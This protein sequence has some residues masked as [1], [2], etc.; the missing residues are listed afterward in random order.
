MY[1]I[2]NIFK[3]VSI[4]EY[5]NYVCERNNIWNLKNEL[6]NYNML[7]CISLYEILIKFNSLIFEKFNLNIT[8][9]PT[10]PSLAFGIYRA[11]F[12]NDYKIP[13][14]GGKLYEDIRKSYTGGAT[15]MYIPYGTNLYHYD[16]NSL[17]PTSMFKFDMP[18]GNI[19]YFTGNIL[20]FMTNPFGFFKVKIITPKYLDNPILQIRY[21]DRTVSPLG[22]FTGWFFSE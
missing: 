15:E 18:I 11:H 12:L 10:L 4:T 17:Y 13:K 21:N 5:N 2:L 9:F 1:Q 22:T 20:E 8:R 6:L 14:I 19:K 16:I 7:D 3:N